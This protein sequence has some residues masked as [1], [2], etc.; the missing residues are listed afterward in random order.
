MS[1]IGEKLLE[2][3]F[4]ILISVFKKSYFVYLIIPLS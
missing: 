1:A 4:D 2:N 3:D